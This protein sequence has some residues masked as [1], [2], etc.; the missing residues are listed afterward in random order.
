MTRFAAAMLGLA[1]AAGTGF[2]QP[3]PN[4]APRPT[5]SPY[6][7]LLRGGGGGA[8][9]NYFG[10]VRPEIQ[11]RQQANSLQQ[12]L[13]AT[14]QNLTNIENQLLQPGEQPGLAGTGHGVVFN[15]PFRYFNTL[16]G[17]SGGA[18]GAS[19]GGSPARPATSSFS[20]GGGIYAGAAVRTGG[21]GGMTRPAS[22]GNAPSTW[23]R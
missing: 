10:L 18:R 17:G 9:I 19:G 15:Q 7:N 6:L 1:V 13:N 4:V 12:Q 16:P 2:S 3:Q 22:G 5:F 23:P 21:G 8:G 20:S 11:M 14:N